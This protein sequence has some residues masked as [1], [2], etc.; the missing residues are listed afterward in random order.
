MFP[1]MPP[2]ILNLNTAKP[3]GFPKSNLK[4]KDFRIFFFFFNCHPTLKSIRNKSTKLHER[5]DGGNNQVW[6]NDSV[7]PSFYL[8]FVSFRSLQ[9][10]WERGKRGGEGAEF[11]VPS[12][13]ALSGLQSPRRL[14][15]LLPF[16]VWDWGLWRRSRSP[17]A[18][19]AP[20]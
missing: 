13:G 14:R 5:L 2:H 12:Q 15:L 8:I 7:S 20:K 19:S 18:P 11:A 6:K 10:S 1:F 9:L 3:Q 4:F 17:P 16:V